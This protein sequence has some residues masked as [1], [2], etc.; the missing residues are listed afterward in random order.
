MAL[1]QNRFDRILKMLQQAQFTCTGHDGDMICTKP[2]DTMMTVSIQRS[3]KDIAMRVWQ[4]KKV[5]RFNLKKQTDTLEIDDVKRFLLNS[6]KTPVR[7]MAED[8][9]MYERKPEA[10]L[11]IKVF[12]SP[13]RIDIKFGTHN[14]LP[15]V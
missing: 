4:P 12:K 11:V 10:D 5:V 6:G 9:F 2:L 3:A 8:Q 14:R 1:S 15:T 7:S 13:D